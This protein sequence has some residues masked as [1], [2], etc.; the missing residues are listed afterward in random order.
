MLSHLERKVLKV[1]P[2]FWLGELRLLFAIECTK[3]SPLESLLWSGTM[4]LQYAQ[5]Y[6]F[7]NM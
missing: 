4:P 7:T 5:K 3:L 2:G 1:L 6:K